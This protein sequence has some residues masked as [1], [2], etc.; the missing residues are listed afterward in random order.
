MR[1]DPYRPYPTSPPMKRRRVY[2]GSCPVRF[3]YSGIVGPRA[4]RLPHVAYPSWLRALLDLFVL[5]V[6]RCSICGAP[7]VREEL[8]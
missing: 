5:P 7:F 2:G 6:Y 8:S 3:V 4:V 1:P